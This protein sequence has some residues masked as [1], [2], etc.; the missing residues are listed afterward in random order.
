MHLTPAAARKALAAKLVS[1]FR[2][3]NIFL[4]RLEAEHAATSLLAQ[5]F[6]RLATEQLHFSG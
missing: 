4:I 3:L 6:R 1:Y 5:G 2:P